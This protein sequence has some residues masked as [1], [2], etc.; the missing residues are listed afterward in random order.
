MKILA[1]SGSAR[2]DGNTDALVDIVASEIESAGIECETV[3]LAREDVHGCRACW[4]CAGKGNCAFGDDAFCAIFDKM[5]KADG[6]VLASP[7]YTGNVSANMQAI[8]ERAAVVCD[9]NK[10]DGLL[11]RKAGGCLAVARRGGAL[12]TLDVMTNFFLVQDMYVAGSSYWPIAYGRLPKEALQDKE[13]VETA[14]RLGQNLSY[15][16][17]A[18]SC[19][20][21]QAQSQYICKQ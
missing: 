13:G 10:E 12:S 6:I 1:I 18:L 21:N 17:N 9:T 20:S 5:K 4:A 15:L 19:V 8:L 14:R 11:S 16:V 7:V 2:E 3:R